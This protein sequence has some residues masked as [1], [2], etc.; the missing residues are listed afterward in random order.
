MSHDASFVVGC[1]GG[2]GRS[3]GSPVTYSTTITSS[4]YYLVRHLSTSPPCHRLMKSRSC[5]EVG[6]TRPHST[7]AEVLSEPP[8]F[9]KAVEVKASTS[10][11]TA[12]WNTVGS[13]SPTTSPL[14]HL[15]IITAPRPAFSTLPPYRISII[16]RY[17]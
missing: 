3:Y 15:I 9:W 10:E 11:H 17:W 2:S 6:F 7:Q 5:P 8:D 12:S 16:V 14:Q 4:A 1:L 13:T